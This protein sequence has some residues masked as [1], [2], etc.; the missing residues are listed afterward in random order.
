MPE[1][2]FVEVVGSTGAGDPLQIGEIA[3]K[4]GMVLLFTATVS[5]V[6]VAH[7]PPF[8]VNVLAPEIDQLPFTVNEESDVGGA[9]SVPLVMFRSPTTV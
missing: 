1:I 7:C 4:F 5:V 8:G 2:P 9:D 3:L 6:E